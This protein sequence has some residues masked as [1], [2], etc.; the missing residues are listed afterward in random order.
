MCQTPKALG[1]RSQ[2]L[3]ILLSVVSLLCTPSP[4]R[5]LS[6]LCLTDA[7]VLWGCGWWDS[8]GY[9]AA[10]GRCSQSHH[11][12]RVQGAVWNCKEQVNSSSKSRMAPT[13]V[14]FIKEG[15]IESC[16]GCSPG[17]CDAGF[18]ACGRALHFACTSKAL[19]PCSHGES[20]F[21]QSNLVLW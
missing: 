6:D 8:G 11:S 3:L 21:W 5:P 17:W 20:L 10:V 9:R 2:E 7:E 1:V 19:F 14:L 18:Q 12:L 15:G 4:L 13:G 16:K